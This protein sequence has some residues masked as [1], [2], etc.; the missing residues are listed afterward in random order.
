MI[1]CHDVIILIPGDIILFGGY[2]VN[3]RDVFFTEDYFIRSILVVR[4]I[5]FIVGPILLA[6]INM[7]TLIPLHYHHYY[8]Y[9]QIHTP[10]PL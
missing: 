10:N 5:V 9:P 4:F 2:S 8:F 7:A 1:L 6:T 3:E